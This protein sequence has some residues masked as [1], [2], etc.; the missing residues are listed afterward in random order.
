M[1]RKPPPRPGSADSFWE[2]GQTKRDQAARAR[3]R[4]LGDEI[5]ALPEGEKRKVELMASYGAPRE[6]IA[7]AM[8]LT[9]YRLEQLFVAELERGASTLAVNLSRR[10]AMGALGA[11]AE[12]DAE[13]RMVRAEIKPD[14]RIL[15]FA[16][17]R[18]AGWKRP[19]MELTGQDGGAIR[20]TYEPVDFQSFTDEELNTLFAL[21]EKALATHQRRLDG[22]SDDGGGSPG[23]AGGDTGRADSTRH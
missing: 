17:E 23:P 21:N 13:G 8:G 2:P 9:L 6:Q 15:L 22:P 5:A 12:Y 4:F 3:H 19:P 14:W 20:H 10:V 16:A 11:P 1:P 7:R 18:R